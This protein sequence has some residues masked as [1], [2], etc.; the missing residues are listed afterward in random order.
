VPAKDFQGQAVISNYLTPTG[1]KVYTPDCLALRDPVTAHFKDSRITSFEGPVDMVADVEAHYARVA[2]EFGLDAYNIDSW[3]AGIHPLMAYDRSA[4]D[5]PVRWSG[6]AFP[7]PR[8]LHF[9][10][11]GSGPPGEICWMILD[12]TV[13]IDG[14]ALWE[15][16][17]LHPE[18]FESSRQILEQSPE[19]AAAFAAPAGPVGL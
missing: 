14:V 15:D 3:H 7:H 18:R 2:D 5:D 1:S 16:G 13:V 19:L 8:L 11:C 17:R 10:T 4:C 6:T 9:H 12:P